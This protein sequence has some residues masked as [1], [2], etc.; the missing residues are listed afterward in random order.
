MR[1]RHVFRGTYKTSDFCYSLFSGSSL[2]FFCECLDHDVLP[3]L[4]DKNKHCPGIE[5]P[6]KQFYYWLKRIRYVEETMTS[7]DLGVQRHYFAMIKNRPLYNKILWPV[8]IVEVSSDILNL[9]GKA[10]T[11]SRHHDARD[12]SNKVDVSDMALVFPYEDRFQAFRYTAQDIVNYYNDPDNQLVPDEE[13]LTYKNPVIR[14]LIVEIVR[15]ITGIYDAG[16]VYYDFSLPRF[17]IDNTGTQSTIFLDFTNLVFGIEELYRADDYS[18]LMIEEPKEIEPDFADPFFMAY[19][20]MIIPD[21]Q[22][23]LFSLCS[24]LFFLMFGRN[25]YSGGISQ[26][27]DATLLQHYRIA[28]DRLKEP[29][30]IFD[31]D[32]KNNINRLG[33]IS[34]D[35]AVIDLFENAPAQLKSMFIR[36]LSYKNAKRIN[37]NLYAPSLKEWLDFFESSGWI[38]ESNKTILT[39]PEN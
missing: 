30:F 33:I 19:D 8:D 25:A 3:T 22:T 14:K 28:M 18:E 2:Y 31:E 4:I 5:T 27:S 26:E 38:S 10:M 1:K 29:Y 23:F 15:A 7:K 36:T 32:E 24:L 6:D 37:D 9:E 11:V 20:E 34:A 35:T 17:S 12:D 21:E 13:K 39:V 16:N